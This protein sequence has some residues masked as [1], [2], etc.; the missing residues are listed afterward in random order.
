[1]NRRTQVSILAAYSL[2]MLWLLFGQRLMG[3][4]EGVLQLRPFS[5][6]RRFLWVLVN[7]NNPELRRIAWANL[8][9][10]VVIFLPLGCLL[11]W[12]W[13]FFRNFWRHMLSMSAIVL[14][15]ELS[16]YFLRLGTCDVDD[17][18][19]NLLGTEIG[20]LFWKILKK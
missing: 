2:L 17:L 6:L 1:M 3:E 11:P 18:L 19:L 7:S 12:I 5:T 9:G 10:N 13:A 20:Y 4:S 16:Q 14:A 8:A 15:V